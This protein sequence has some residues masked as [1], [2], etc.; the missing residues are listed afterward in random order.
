MTIG[1]QTKPVSQ[2]SR[3]IQTRCL[4]SGCLTNI[5]SKMKP[6]DHTSRYPKDIS[7]ANDIRRKGCM[8]P[9]CTTVRHEFSS[10]PVN[11]SRQ[12]L[13]SNTHN[14][15]FLQ[16]TNVFAVCT[17]LPQPLLEDGQTD[18]RATGQLRSS[19]QARGCSHLSLNV[20]YI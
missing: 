3:A 15:N 10:Y 1:A 18:E 14:P 7:Q 8:R 2:P 16:R 20:E 9:S 19:M 5:I 12:Q 13:A 6:T 11:R 17:C 4:A